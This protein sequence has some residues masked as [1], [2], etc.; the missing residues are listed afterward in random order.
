[1]AR[2][3]KLERG[4]HPAGGS[5]LTQQHETELTDINRIVK[6]YMATGEL[7]QAPVRGLYGDFTSADDFHTM[8]NR[9]N[10]AEDAFDALPSE[11]RARYQNDP[12]Q[13]IDVMSNPE[14]QSE[15]EDL[16]YE[17]HHGEPR[18]P[19]QTEEKPSTTGQEEPEEPSSEES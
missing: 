9:I 12:A 11:I 3:K 7:P 18:P 4:I 16:I 5:S 15:Y 14:R 19:A 2:E 1:M 17:L 10:A 8:L 13:I 6:R